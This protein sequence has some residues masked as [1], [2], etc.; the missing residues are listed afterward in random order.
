MEVVVLIRSSQCERRKTNRAKLPRG[1]R[2]GF[3][4]VSSLIYFEQVKNKHQ[5]NVQRRGE[6]PQ[7]WLIHNLNNMKHPQCKRHIHII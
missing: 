4:T 1:E 5:S 2:K 3:L 6:N 7:E